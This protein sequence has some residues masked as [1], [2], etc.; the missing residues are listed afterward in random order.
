MEIFTGELL[1]TIEERNRLYGDAARCTR[2]DHGPSACSAPTIPEEEL[3]QA[4][5]DAMNA[6]LE[7]SKDVKYILEENILEVIYQDNSDDIDKIN[8]D[9]A[10][11]QEE[12]LELVHGKK[13]YSKCADEMEGLRQNK[14]L[15]LVEYAKSEGTKQ[16]TNELSEYIDQIKVYDDRFTVCFMAK[17]EIGING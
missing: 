11:K 17:V 16:R 10:E 7:C 12:L 15:Q 8:K 4:V 3:Q 14:Q 5:V 2:V 9:I 6:I 1:G 13:D